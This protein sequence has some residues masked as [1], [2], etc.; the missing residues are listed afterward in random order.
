[1]PPDQKPVL[2]SEQALLDVV[3]SIVSQGTIP[4]LLR[5][6]TA[7]LTRFVHFDRLILLLQD[8]AR[9]LIEVAGFYS[10]R[11]HKIYIGL[12]FGLD[13]S[14]AGEVIREQKRR[15]IADVAAETR[16][17]NLV[18][19]L[20]EEN[21]RSTCH[22]PL[23]SAAH[24]LGVLV[25]ATES[26]IPYSDEEL[27]FMDNVL[28]PIAIAVEN[29]LNRERVE[30]ERDRLRLQLEINNA[31]V[32]QHHLS[33][34]FEHVSDLVREAVPHEFLAV[35]IVDPED[36]NLRF[37]V[38]AN[39]SQKIF[40]LQDQLVP[41]DTASGQAFKSGQPEIYDF[42]RISRVEGDYGRNLMEQH[43]RSMCAI[44]LKTARGK[45][46]VISVGSREDDAYTSAKLNTLLPLAAQLAIAV[47]NAVSFERVEELN[48]RLNEA[49]L[50][51]EEELQ[52]AT[53][54]DEILGSSPG[55]RKVLQ[56]I[57][58]VA[59]TDATVL[60]YGET[61]SG[62]ELV[63]RAL[64]QKNSR[65][66][67]TF[68]KLNC[69]AIPTGLLESELFGHEKGAFTGAIAQK[70]GRFEIAHQGTLFLD[71]IGEIPLE[72][73]PKLLRVLQEKEF[74]RLGGTRTIRTDARLVAATNRDLKKMAEA[75]QFRGDLYYRLNV[76]PI[77]V[78]PLRDRKEDIPYLAMHFAQEFSRRFGKHIRSIP[79]DAVD[80][81]VRYHWPGN[82]RELQNLIERS[83][84][85]STGDTL[86]ISLH[87]LDV[88]EQEKPEESSSMSGTGTMD[89]VEREAIRRALKEAKGVI[90][91]PK[92][93][94]AKLGMKR[95]TLLY[96]M[97]KLGIQKPA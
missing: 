68:V 87:E 21:I 19:I 41:E 97:D 82:I 10:A 39:P 45:V 69:A 42:S 24:R 91:G 60:V 62:K 5:E 32:T 85:L 11:P 43:I 44:P 14:P 75:N 3:S 23:T 4:E 74:E 65:R 50:Y 29:I 22:V 83:T 81:L 9:G 78:P 76:F 90:G 20:R 36:R 15:Y 94:A 1:M 57:E 35:S 26:G 72:L 88:E 86:R 7:R 63:A 71:E 66:S 25:F 52:S 18:K 34:L 54:S 6:L 47:E 59:P 64:H 48:R 56:Q 2:D 12:T 70:V 28:K 95:T 55:I 93:A 37:R 58:I 31:L 89:D 84:I 8:E 30:Q 79:A 33:G 61:G 46:G 67:G 27:S 16:Y 73:Q 13:D 51:L 38:Q 53:P 17:P 80:R 96:R 92:G 77:L 40:R 49:K